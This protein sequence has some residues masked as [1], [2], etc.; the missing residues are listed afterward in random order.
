MNAVYISNV[1]NP[2][3]FSHTP[4]PET[5]IVSQYRLTDKPVVTHEKNYKCY[6]IDQPNIYQSI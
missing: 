3:I 1:Y 2:L 4:Y 6:E 5:G